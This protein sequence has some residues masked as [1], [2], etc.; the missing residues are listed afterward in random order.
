[1]VCELKITSGSKQ[2]CKNSMV[3]RHLLRVNLRKSVMQRMKYMVALLKGYLFLI[4]TTF[5]LNFIW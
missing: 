4:K 2:M 1:M 5:C 3:N